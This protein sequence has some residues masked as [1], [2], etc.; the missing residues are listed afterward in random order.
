VRACLAG[1]A[2]IG[3]RLDGACADQHF[4]IVLVGLQRE[5]GRQRDES[6]KDFRS[7]PDHPMGGRSERSKAAK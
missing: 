6:L 3:F 5:G 7:N 2:N 4:P 1:G